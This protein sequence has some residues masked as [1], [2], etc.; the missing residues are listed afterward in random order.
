MSRRTDLQPAEDGSVDYRRLLNQLTLKAYR[1]MG[2]ANLAGVEPVL[3]EHGA[4]PEDFAIA[5]L[6][7]MLTQQLNFSGPPDKLFA[8]LSKVMTR[9]ILDALKKRGVKAGRQGKTV[10][11][12]DG[13]FE[14]P[15]PRITSEGLWNIRDLLREDAFKQKLQECIQDD[16]G[17]QE[18]VYAVSEWDEGGVP[19]PREIADI[20]GVSVTEI[21]NRKRKLARRLIKQ[22]VQ[23]PHIRR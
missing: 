15:D 16:A 14:A 23:L 19:A 1:F 3:A 7:K 9:D 6:G 12:D 5:A 10:P 13:A 11:I 22:G 21:Q 8:F 18:F 2:L 4:S 17:L 20:I